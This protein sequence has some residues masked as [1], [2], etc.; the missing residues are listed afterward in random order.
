MKYKAYLGDTRVK[1]PGYTIG[2]KKI[3]K[4]R[5]KF[6][7]TFNIDVDTYQD[8]V[9]YEITAIDD[10]SKN[11]L[12]MVFPDLSQYTHAYYPMGTSSKEKW[13]SY[14]GVKLR[15]KMW[16]RQSKTSSLQ[17]YL[18]SEDTM[19]V[20]V[21][22]SAIEPRIAQPG[23]NENNLGDKSK[24]CLGEFIITPFRLILVKPDNNGNLNNERVWYASEARFLAFD[25][26]C[27]GKYD[28]ARESSYEEFVQHHSSFGAG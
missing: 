1:A 10:F 18:L 15:H 23:Y 2:T 11:L 22:F 14:H 8:V 27:L 19:V 17:W 4:H 13:H 7:C 6:N 28:S 5:K 12:S 24:P 26:V 20:S 25:G 3:K 9:N 21:P 16:S